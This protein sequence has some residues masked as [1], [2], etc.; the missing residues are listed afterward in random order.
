MSTPPE[1]FA[2]TSISTA[3]PP[4]ISAL[5]PAAGSLVALLSIAG[6]AIFTAGPAMMS[7]MGM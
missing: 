4:L 7:A 1:E 2:M 3:R 5:L 6:I